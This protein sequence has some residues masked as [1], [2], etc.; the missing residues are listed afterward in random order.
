M[1][2]FIQTHFVSNA[3]SPTSTSSRKWVVAHRKH[4][5]RV[6]GLEYEASPQFGVRNDKGH[7][8]TIAGDLLNIPNSREW[9]PPVLQ[10]PSA[11]PHSVVQRRRHEPDAHDQGH[12][13]SAPAEFVK[14]DCLRPRVG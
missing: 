10:Y 4:D 5:S 1:S 7:I 11:K 2:G 3:I 9:R 12:N 14:N 6:F 13:A 8:S